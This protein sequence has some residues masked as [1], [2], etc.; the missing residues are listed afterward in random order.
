LAKFFKK[1]NNMKKMERLFKDL[2]LYG[3]KGTFEM[4]INRFLAHYFCNMLDVSP[5]EKLLAK[6]LKVFTPK[7]YAEAVEYMWLAQKKYSS[8]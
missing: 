8:K 3:L 4:R 2:G 1:E 5:R 6:L 7:L